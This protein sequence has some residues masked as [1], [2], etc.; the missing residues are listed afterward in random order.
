VHSLLQKERE[1]G[2]KVR[3]EREVSWLT[4]GTDTE[5]ISFLKMPGQM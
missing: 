5:L 2:A 1:S 3:D 4:F